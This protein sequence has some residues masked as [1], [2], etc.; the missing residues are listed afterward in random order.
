AGNI[1]LALL[2]LAQADKPFTFVSIFTAN[3]D[4]DGRPIG[5][6]EVVFAGAGHDIVLGQQGDDILFGGDGDDDL[7]G[8]HNVA[9]GQD[10]AD[11][12]DAGAG[13]DV[14]AGDN[15]TIHRTGNN[16]SPRVRVLA[17]NAM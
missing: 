9:G 14:V 2:P 4:A 15:A 16:I 1:D 12:I 7:I 17:G 8:G 6:D 11:V 10:G 5:G 13:Y 3:F